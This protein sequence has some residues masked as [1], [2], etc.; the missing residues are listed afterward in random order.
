MVASPALGRGLLPV[1]PVAWSAPSV[2]AAGAAVAPPC[3]GVQ[4]EVLPDY[5]GPGQCSNL[6]HVVG[7]GD[8]D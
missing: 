2:P 7:G 5:R 8:L 3:S 6:S 4:T 1:A